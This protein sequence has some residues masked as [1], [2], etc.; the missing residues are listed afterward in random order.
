MPPHPTGKLNPTQPTEAEPQHYIIHDQSPISQRSVRAPKPTTNDE[1]YVPVDVQRPQ[2]LVHRWNALWGPQL[3]VVYILQTRLSSP[4]CFPLVKEVIHPVK[5]LDLVQYRQGEVGIAN[6]VTK[7]LDIRL[8]WWK[9][10]MVVGCKKDI[11]V[12]GWPY[13][14]NSNRDKRWAGVGC[15]AI[16]LR[17]KYTHNTHPHPHT[18]TS[19]HTT[20]TPQG[21]QD[22]HTYTHPQHTQYTSTPTHMARHITHPHHTP[23][24]T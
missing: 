12:S 11:N 18:R 15:S 14:T 16:R 2:T 21:P 13:K 24:P 6:E 8:V 23:T 4:L 5:P 22:R 9:A 20:Y 17:G 10:V 7:L 1:R 19:P 3:S